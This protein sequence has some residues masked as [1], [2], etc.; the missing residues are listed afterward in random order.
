M[1][2]AQPCHQIGERDLG[3]VGHAAEHAFGEKGAS[4]GNAVNAAH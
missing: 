2:G 3:R 4:E 1:A